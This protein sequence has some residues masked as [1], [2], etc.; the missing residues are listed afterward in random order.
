[1]IKGNTKGCL[2]KFEDVKRHEPMN[3]RRTYSL[4]QQVKGF[5]FLTSGR[6][7]TSTALLV[8]FYPM[9]PICSFQ[10]WNSVIR[11]LCCQKP[12]SRNRAVCS[13]SKTFPLNSA[14]LG[15]I[16]VTT[17]DSLCL[18]GELLEFSRAWSVP[19]VWLGVVPNKLK[20]KIHLLCIIGMPVKESNTTILINKDNR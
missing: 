10:V 7:K 4:E 19:W 1:M 15:L 16:F 14:D 18:P 20:K 3:V 11:N 2:C 5:S 17:C 6:L 13:T 9:R 12:P 8:N